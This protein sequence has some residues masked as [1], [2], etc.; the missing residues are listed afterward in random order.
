M[1]TAAQVASHTVN[2][3]WIRGHLK[4]H[5]QQPRSAHAT[6]AATRPGTC[7]VQPAVQPPRCH[8]WE[9]GCLAPRKWLGITD[10]AVAMC[11]Y[12]CP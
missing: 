10:V 6:V 12:M 4:L 8:G 2:T 9:I 7:A 5:A 3:L 1:E 11:D